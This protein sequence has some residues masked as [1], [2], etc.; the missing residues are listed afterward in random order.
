MIVEIP[1]EALSHFFFFVENFL[2]V[3]G[4]SGVMMAGVSDVAGG[5]G[6][7]GVVG[8]DGRPKQSRVMVN[9]PPLTI[10]TITCNGFVPPCP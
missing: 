7:A 9:P 6:V 5:A 2:D 10:T 4:D 8:G 3:D 1:V